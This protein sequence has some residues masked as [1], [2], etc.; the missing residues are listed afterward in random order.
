ME[1]MA[2]FLT[3]YVIKKG[4]I[5]NTERNL[6][7]YGFQVSLEMGL[8][9]L[10]C[11]AIAGAL[12]MGME[13]I[14]FF[15]IFIPLRS[16]AGGLHLDNYWSCLFLSCLTF[17]VILMICKI[18]RIEAYVSFFILLL[19]ILFVWILYPVENV[20]R[21]VDEKENL[22]FRK[23]LRRYLLLDVIISI[24]CM[25]LHKETYLLLCMVTFFMVVVTMLIGKMK[26][27][28]KKQ[29]RF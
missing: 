21:D 17:S 11:S 8:C 13:G 24:A 18:W 2:I 19:L 20:N 4:V 7:K 12:G 14:L 22:Y 27:K 28:I 6:Y 26:N 29:N 10:I 25:A 1:K 15:I 3:D 5:E 23:K 9:I 16:Y